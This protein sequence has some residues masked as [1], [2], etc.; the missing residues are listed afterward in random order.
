MNSTKWT[1][2]APGIQAWKKGRW[3]GAA[4][5]I[6]ESEWYR[7]ALCNSRDQFTTKADIGAPAPLCSEHLVICC[8]HDMAEKW[9]SKERAGATLT[10]NC[11]T[12]T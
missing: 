4:A 2:Y 5:A 12:D 8:M 10:H 11:T 9:C 6:P 3:Q 1:N 7:K